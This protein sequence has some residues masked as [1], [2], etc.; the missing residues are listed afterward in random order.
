MD[1]TR[2]RIE[3]HEQLNRVTARM[4][5]IRAAASKPKSER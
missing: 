4:V 5:G 2:P 3:G 1:A